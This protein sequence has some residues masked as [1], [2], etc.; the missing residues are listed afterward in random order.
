MKLCFPYTGPIPPPIADGEQVTKEVSK[1]AL[2]L[3]R[4]GD[5]AI[6]K[7]NKH[8]PYGAGNIEHDLKSSRYRS[9]ETMEY[10]RS[11]TIPGKK[12]KDPFEAVCRQA[13]I[14][15]A[16]KGGNCGEHAR[17]CAATL[18]K[19]VPAGT[20]IN[21]CEFPGLD[22]AFVVLG[23]LGIG[24]R[25]NRKLVVV[26]A[27]PPKAQ[28]VMAEDFFAGDAAKLRAFYS[29][30]AE[31]PSAAGKKRITGLI[32]KVINPEGQPAATTP[33][34]TMPDGTCVEYETWDETHVTAGKEVFKYIAGVWDT[35]AP[36]PITAPVPGIT[37]N[38]FYGLVPRGQWKYHGPFA[39]AEGGR[40]EVKMEGTN[41][42]D[43]FI[44]KGGEP[45]AREYDAVSSGPDSNETASVDGGGEYY[46][47][48]RG[49]RGARYHIEI[50]YNKAN[51]SGS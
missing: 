10:T 29:F 16:G 13:A 37:T 7:V 46:I 20:R 28:A 6:S 51:S 11:C 47:G 34:P 32:P 25:E 19:L 1:E 41:D 35:S 39:V 38:I 23:K 36:R 17:D 31:G 8:L 44:R 40:L 50:N 5:L 45:S 15:R 27:W 21:V 49:I 42:A 3:L 43:L 24:D 2:E 18:N 30:V 12:P 48:I 33:A 9:Y 14:V 26:D 22:H 4:T